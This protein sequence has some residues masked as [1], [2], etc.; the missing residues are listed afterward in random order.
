MLWVWLP[1]IILFILVKIILR[2][3]YNRL[4]K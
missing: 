1:L 4:T 3:R 2:I